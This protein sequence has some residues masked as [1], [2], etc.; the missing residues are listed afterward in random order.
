MSTYK[1]LAHVFG[2]HT[3]SLRMCPHSHS[4]RC[5]GHFFCLRP[6]SL[7]ILTHLGT[8]MSPGRA[9][10]PLSTPLGIWRRFW[11]DRSRF[12]GACRVR[13]VPR[14]C[15]RW[16]ALI[17]QTHGVLLRRFCHPRSSVK[18]RDD[19]LKWVWMGNECCFGQRMASETNQSEARSVCAIRSLWSQEAIWEPQHKTFPL[20]ERLLLLLFFLI[21]NSEKS[22]YS[23]ALNCL[24]LQQ[25]LKY[26]S[27]FLSFFATK[28]TFPSNTDFDTHFMQLPFSFLAV[29]VRHFLILFE[30]ESLWVAFLKN[31]Q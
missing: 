20:T 22:K 16:G 29:M 1:F 19:R 21:F 3:S 11:S 9:S 5:H 12:H 2:A 25:W 31:L 27:E 30:T 14:R 26:G 13:I 8:R 24:Y 28:S 17:F 10:W 6:S 18:R 7:R 23:F 4:N 15:L